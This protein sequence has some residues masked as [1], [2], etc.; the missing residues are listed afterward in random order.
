[1]APASADLMHKSEPMTNFRLR[2]A[3]LSQPIAIAP[4]PERGTRQ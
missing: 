2:L 4:A 3:A 1:M